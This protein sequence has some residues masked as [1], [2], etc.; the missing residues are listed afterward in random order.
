MVV[1]DVQDHRQ[2]KLMRG[3]NEAL[4]GIGA[5]IGCL[6]GV[7]G[8]SVIAPVA[9]P[10]KRRDWHDLDRRDAEFF[11]I[12]KFGDRGLKSAFGRE[13]ADVQLKNDVAPKGESPPLVIGP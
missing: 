9:G 7:G 13:C 6:Y 1:D 8:D 11:Q 4:E 10:G 5:T 2:A 3:V 12:W